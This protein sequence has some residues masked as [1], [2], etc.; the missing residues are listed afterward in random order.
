MGIVVL[1]LVHIE[2]QGYP[3]GQDKSPVNLVLTVLAAGGPL[4]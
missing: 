1:V 2:I 3:S 4:L